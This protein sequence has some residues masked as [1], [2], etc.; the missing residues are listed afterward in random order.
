MV[1]I[2]GMKNCIWCTRAVKLCQENGI[3]YAYMDV[4]TKENVELFKSLFPQAK[5][6]PQ[7][8][9]DGFAIGGYTELQQMITAEAIMNDNSELL[10]SLADN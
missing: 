1:R 9:Y 2:Y 8:M 4:D 3:E 5:T 7:I 6:V 10:K